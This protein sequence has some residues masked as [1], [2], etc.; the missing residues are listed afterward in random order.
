MAKE[1]EEYKGIDE[2]VLHGMNFKS[3]SDFLDKKGKEAEDYLKSRVEGEGGIKMTADEVVEFQARNSELATATKHWETLREADASF[4]KTKEFLMQMNRVNRPPMHDA[5]GHTRPEAIKTLGDLFTESEAYKSFHGRH[6]TTTEYQV[7][8]EDV[9]VEQAL[10]TTITTAAGFAQ[11]A[12]RIPLVVDYALRR[13]VVA[14]LIPQ[15]MT[16]DKVIRYMEETTFTNNAAPVAENA[17]KPESA[18]AWTERSQEVEVI[19][20]YIPVTNQQLDDIP[21]MKALINQRMM[22]MLQLAEEAQLLSGSG[23]TPQLTGFYNKSGVQTQAKGSDPVPDAIFKAFTK[24]RHTGFAEPSGVVLHPNDWQDIRLIRT[25]DGIYI[26]GSPSEA[27]PER[28]WGKPV[29]A[30]T[31]AT[32]NTGLT[33]DFQLYSHIWRRMGATVIVGRIN[34]DLVKNKQTVLCELREA[35]TIYRAAAFCLVT[36]I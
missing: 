9:D 34:D 30:T 2:T 15:T 13:P 32:E 3:L 21:Q 18:L 8:L 24:V 27:G 22:L 17:A 19:A 28:I 20:H 33:G 26:W 29:I 5:G 23:T 6:G 7:S 10:K 25:L 14:D 4:I 31:A 35:L 11:E 1:K 36:G 12:T 16:K